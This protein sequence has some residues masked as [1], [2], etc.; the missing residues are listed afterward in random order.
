MFLLAHA[1][2]RQLLGLAARRG[3]AHA[4]HARH[5]AKSNDDAS[6][7]AGWMRMSCG[8]SVASWPGHCAG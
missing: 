2:R 5:D 1:E 7:S 4:D 8:V 6:P 3:L